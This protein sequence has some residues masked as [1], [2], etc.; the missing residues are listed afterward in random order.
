MIAK[1]TKVKFSSTLSVLNADNNTSIYPGKSINDAVVFEEPIE[2][3]KYLRLK[4]AAKGCG[5]D[6]EFRF[7]IPSQMIKR[8]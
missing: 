3:V 1:I 4:L 7:Q 2:D 8:K 5:E 6:G